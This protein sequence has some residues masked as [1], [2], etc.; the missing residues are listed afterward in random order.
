MS[1]GVPAVLRA[2][3]TKLWTLAGARGL[4]A[5]AVVAQV[6]V[7]AAVAASLDPA[8]APDPV[9]SSLAGVWA[10]QVAV[11]VLGV[12]AMSSEYETPQIRVTLAAV[13]RRV[14]VLAAKA[15]A[16][17]A[18]VAGAGVLGTA[19]SLAAGRL[20]LAG[21][22]LAVP[23]WTGS[24]ARAAAG[25][26]CY[27]VLV[28]LLA[29]GLGTLVRDAAVAIVATLAALFLFPMLGLVVSD[30]AWQH[31]LHRYAPMDAG[32]AVQ[33]TRRLGDLPVGPWAGVG[34]LAAYA[35]ACLLTSGAVF[36]ARDA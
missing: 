3:R 14:A 2:E 26:V 11:V 8:R 27:L 18:L 36:Q 20:V 12:L 33:A 17:A 31:R 5:G 23:L 35:A 4:L 7:G 21:N 24:T 29:L 19:G 9:R 1:V 30:P 22:G 32:L 25:T 34:I 13:P 10:A 28:A 6:A 16:V 15:A